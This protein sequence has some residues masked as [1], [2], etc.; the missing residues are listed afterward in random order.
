VFGFSKYKERAS[1]IFE[2]SVSREVDSVIIACSKLDA[3]YTESSLVITKVTVFIKIL[4]HTYCLK[5]IA[6]SV[7]VCLTGGLLAHPR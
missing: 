7:E 6:Y 2:K 3:V 1:S 5:E 4:Y